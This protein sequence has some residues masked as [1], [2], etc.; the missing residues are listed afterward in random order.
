VVGFQAQ[1]SA[2]RHHRIVQR[3]RPAPLPQDTR[4]SV[5]GVG[6]IGVQLKLGAEQQESSREMRWMPS[7]ESM[8]KS[9][10]ESEKRDENVSL[11]HFS[12]RVNARKS[13]SMVSLSSSS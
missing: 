2:V 13:K 7:Y 1:R 12:M 11:S 6:E 8:S 10:E 9:M 4:Q 5:V 3:R